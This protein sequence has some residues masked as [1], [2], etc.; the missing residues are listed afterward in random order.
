MS[1]HFSRLAQLSLPPRPYCAKVQVP[2]ACLLTWSTGPEPS[3][4]TP[5]FQAGP[6]TRGL[7]GRPSASASRATS[8]SVT[9]PDARYT[10][11]EPGPFGSFPAAR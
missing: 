9:V 10:G 4:V 11:A 8:A 6:S 1:E 3:L 2:G 7:P 5:A